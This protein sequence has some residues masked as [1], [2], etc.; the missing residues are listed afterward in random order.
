ML[1]FP[2]P[3]ESTPVALCD[4]NVMSSTSTAPLTPLIVSAGP[5]VADV[6][7]TTGDVPIA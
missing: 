4:S 3:C 7:V 5:P 2:L 6:E 1:E